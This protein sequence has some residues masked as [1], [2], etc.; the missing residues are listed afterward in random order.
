MS[1]LE[2]TFN[3]LLGLSVISWSIMGFLFTDPDNKYTTVRL[4]M[5]IVHLSVGILILSRSRLIRQGSIWQ[6]IGSFPSLI[7][8]GMAIKAAPVHSQW[9]IY[10]QVLFVTGAI[11]AVFAFFSLGKSFAIFPGLRGIVI[12]GPFKFIR[13]PA[14]F[15]ELMM[16]LA[17]GLADPSFIS[18]APFFIAIPLVM[19]RVNIEESILR[20]SE[21]YVEYSEKVK[22]KLLPLVW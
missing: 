21:T 10:C 12:R 2:Y 9:P 17:C 3:L 1:R 16:I 22:Y 19:M 20:C 13:H 5:C 15:G 8:A 11:L 4:T 18:L 14:Y 6:F 7:I